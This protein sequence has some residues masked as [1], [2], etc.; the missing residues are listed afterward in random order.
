MQPFMLRLTLVYWVV[1]TFP[2]VLS[3]EWIAY[4]Y[5]LCM[6]RWALTVAILSFIHRSC[7]HLQHHSLILSKCW[8]AVVTTAAVCL[9]CVTVQH[10][11]SATVAPVVSF[12]PA[13]FSTVLPP[14]H[15]DIIHWQQRDG[16][17][18]GCVCVCVCLGAACPLLYRHL[19]I[20]PW[21][22]AVT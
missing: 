15:H 14:V 11:T 3:S 19:Y 12:I 4:V 22:S 21:L 6:L 8:W 2:S 18:G 9:I 10:W 16:N 17:R 7:C 1:R 5:M 20:A 13:V